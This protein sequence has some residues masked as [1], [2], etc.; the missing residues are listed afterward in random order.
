MISGGSTSTTHTFSYNESGGEITLHNQVGSALALI[1]VWGANG[2]FRLLNV[3]PVGDL[4]FGLGSNNPA[5]EIKFMSA[6]YVNTMSFSAAGNLRFLSGNG[7]DFSPTP[8]AP[9]PITELFDDYEEGDWSAT[10]NGITEGNASKSG[11]YI[12]IGKQVT[13][14]TQITLGTTS[15]VTG[16]I[17]ISNLPYAVSASQPTITG[18]ADLLDGGSNFY[19][20]ICRL[21][22][23]GTSI[24]VYAINTAG[25]YGQAA[26]IGATVPF[27]WVTGDQIYVCITYLAA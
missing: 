9:L 12:K 8:D 10:Y 15:V 27:T 22:T 23:G 14:W 11:K 26:I 18:S 21:E 16:N 6:G 2:D 20:A 25:T 7:I 4:V 19:K 17:S 3:N 1:D 5:G 24:A 13:L